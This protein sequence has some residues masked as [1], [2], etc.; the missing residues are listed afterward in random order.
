MIIKNLETGNY[1][2][3]TLR[4]PNGFKVLFQKL[5]SDSMDQYI[6]EKRKNCLYVADNFS[7][8]SVDTNDYQNES[9]Y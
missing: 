3:I 1:Y 2:E 7:I 6:E 8:S 4:I 9:D 5:Y